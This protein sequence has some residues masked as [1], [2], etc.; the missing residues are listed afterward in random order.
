MQSQIEEQRA[1][2]EQQRESISQ[3]VRAQVNKEVIR[4]RR[5]S[6]PPPEVFST[7]IQKNSRLSSHS[8]MGS[9]HRVSILNHPLLVLDYQSQ[10]FAQGNNRSNSFRGLKAA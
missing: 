9:Q 5:R 1:L 10:G 4:T 3:L 7:L 2:L 6:S 8:S